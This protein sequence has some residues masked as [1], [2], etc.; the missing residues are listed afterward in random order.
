MYLRLHIENFRLFAALRASREQPRGPLVLVDAEGRVAELNSV[1]QTKQILP[2]MTMA[3][4]LSRCSDM[5]VLHADVQAEA[6]AQRILWNAAWQITPQ[7]ELGEGEALGCATLELVRPDSETLSAQV[8]QLLQRLRRCGLPARAG[9][10]ATPDWAILVAT[11]AERFDFKWVPTERR[12]RELLG[13]LPLQVLE[14]LDAKA[15]SVLEGWGIRSLQALAELPRQSLGERLGPVGLDA[16][17]RLNGQRRRV[18]QFRELEPDY[19]QRFDLEEP[20]RDLEAICFLIHRAAEALALQLEQSG[21]LARAVHLDLWVKRAE[22]Y[23]KVIQLPE[24]TCQAA[25][26]ERLLRNHLEQVQLSGAVAGLQLSVEPVDPLSRQAGLFERSVRNPWRL[27]E[28][29]DQLAGLVG[30]E[31]FGSPRVLDSHR[32]DAHCLQPL[33]TDAEAVDVSERSTPQGP[34]LMGPPMRRFRP[35]LRAKVLLEKQFPAHV[36]C[37]LTSGPVARVY[38]PYRSSGDWASAERWSLWEWDVEIEG[39]GTFCLRHE[40]DEWWLVGAYD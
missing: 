13:Y 5:V 9:A 11:A 21:K 36:E 16:W 15:C 35:P 30:M 10:A 19:R 6:A 14:G 26:L 1:A 18:L 7:I 24:A 39:S 22:H 20:V 4:A 3:R 17:D 28:T 2:G 38:G 34:P 23:R 29:L 8:D 32:P 31:A 40:S 37:S 12:M 25:L 33:L 27:Q